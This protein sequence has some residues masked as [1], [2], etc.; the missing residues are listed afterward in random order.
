MV[1]VGCF[2]LDYFK[3]EAYDEA[4]LAVDHFDAYQERFGTLP[5]YLQAIKNTEPWITGNGWAH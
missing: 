5:P 3:H 2:F 1:H 4:E